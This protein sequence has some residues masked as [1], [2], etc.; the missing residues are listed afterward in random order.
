MNI[1][2]D[3]KYIIKDFLVNVVAFIIV[4]QIIKFHSFSSLLLDFLIWTINWYAMSILIFGKLKKY[5]GE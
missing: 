1:K 3:C 5:K 2:I 4:S